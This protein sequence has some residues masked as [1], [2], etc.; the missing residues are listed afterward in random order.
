[1]RA[2]IPYT[3]APQCYQK[4]ILKIAINMPKTKKMWKIF[5]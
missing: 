1:M 4:S 2:E 5:N 3:K